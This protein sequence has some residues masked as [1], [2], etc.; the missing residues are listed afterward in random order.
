VETINGGAPGRE[1]SQIKMVF[2]VIKAASGAAARGL[3]NHTGQME[4][5]GG[6]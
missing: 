2:M 3:A 4:N 5:G 1:E 6:K